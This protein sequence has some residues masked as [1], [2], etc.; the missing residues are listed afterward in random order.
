MGKHSK[1]N[2]QRISF[3]GSSAGAFA[4]LL[5][6]GG[7]FAATQVIDIPDSNDRA[8]KVVE[9]APQTTEQ[10]EKQNGSP[11]PDFTANGSAN[12]ASAAEADV[13]SSRV[14]VPPPADPPPIVV[15]TP[16]GASPDPDLN[17][18]VNLPPLVGVDA[19]LDVT[20]PLLGSA[21]NVVEDVTH[22]VTDPVLDTVEDLL[23]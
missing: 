10:I 22:S 16:P 15:P 14:P 2:P 17:I 5:I 6:A 9:K 23:K 7:I 1:P 13:G 20:V 11:V 4:A 8:P 21:V 3:L 12:A 19:D 18:D